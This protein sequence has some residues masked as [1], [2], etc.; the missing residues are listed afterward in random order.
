LS[1]L[2]LAQQAGG[3]PVSGNVSCLAGYYTS[4]IMPEWDVVFSGLQLIRVRV[5]P[6]DE[7]HNEPNNGPRLTFGAINV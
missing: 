3:T 4:Y 1:G 5:T 6:D 2:R 7:F